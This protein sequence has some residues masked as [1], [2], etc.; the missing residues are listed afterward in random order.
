MV[1]FPEPPHDRGQDRLDLVDEFDVAHDQ[2]QPAAVGLHPSFGDRERRTLAAAALHA[3]A[4]QVLLV[5]GELAL[6]IERADFTS[7]A[8]DDLGVIDAGV[9]DEHLGQFDGLGRR[10]RS[11]RRR[12]RGGP[13]EA[14]ER[15]LLFIHVLDQ[16][17]VRLQR[18]H[19]LRGDP[20]G[21][22]RF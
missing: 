6:E 14:L 21:E 12:R 22:Q 16:V 20:A 7:H 9:A 8:A 17:H 13:L 2:T 5:G 3:E 10:G 11:A 19:L 18:E 4:V 1:F 15:P